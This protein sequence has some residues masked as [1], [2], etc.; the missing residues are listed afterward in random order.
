MMRDRLTAAVR[1]AALAVAGDALPA[2]LPGFTMERPARKEHGDWSANVAMML[3]KPL[4]RPPRAIA[5]QIVD[6]L[7]P[8]PEVERIE[9]AGPG[10]INFALRADSLTEVVREILGAGQRWGRHREP[11]GERINVEF[12]SANPTGPLHVG[13]ARWAALGDALSRILDAAGHTIIREFYVND[14]GRQMDLFGASIAAR[15]LGL[16]SRDAEIPEGGYGG[17][18]VTELAEQIK[19]ADGDRYLE[20]DDAERAKAFRELGRERMLAHQRETLETF[21]VSFDV[22]FSETSLHESGAVERALDRLRD[23]GHGYEQDGALWLRSTDF[24]DDK[25]RVARR[26]DGT[27]TYLA[28][29]IAYYLDKRSRDFDRI[30][31]LWGADHHGYVPRMKAV[32]QAVGDDVETVE[33]LIGQM[34]NLLRGGEPVRM[35]KR[36]GELVTA[37][38]LIDEV[39][40]DAARY[41]LVRQSADTPIDFDIEMVVRQSQDNPVFYVQYAHARIASIGRNAAEQGIARGDLAGAGLSLLTHDSEHDLL[42]KIGEFPEIVELAARR[43][44]PHLIP[45]YAE[46]L[47]GTFHSFYRDCRVLTDDAALTQARLHLCEATRITL[48]NALSLLGVSAPD[49]M[50]RTEEI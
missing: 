21:R 19:A 23:G 31:F 49:R 36:T 22:W 14:Y 1:A 8:L 15:Y 13:H 10:F 28:A 38:E 11:D 44:A 39:G 26:G 5:Q 43:R 6:A 29:D 24:G 12:V 3:A 50:E 41:T 48:A 17:V 2:G 35:S 30:I 27:T 16:F 34:V 40:A 45:R 37:G 20:M 7:E 47:A 4:G 32:A 33:F 42:R 9:I 25:D 18:Y 46:E